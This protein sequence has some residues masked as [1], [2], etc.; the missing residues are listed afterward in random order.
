MLEMSRK[1][2]RLFKFLNVKLLHD[3]SPEN[4]VKLFNTLLKEDYVIQV[5]NRMLELLDFGPSNCAGVYV[6]KIAS[7][8]HSNNVKWF[9]DK[10]KQETAGPYI[11]EDLHPNLKEDYFF[12]VPDRHRIAMFSSSEVSIT[13]LQQY[14]DNACYRLMGKDK[15]STSIEVDP[16]Y[17]KDIKEAKEVTRIV[18]TWSYT[19]KDYGEGLAKVLDDSAKMGNAARITTIMTSAPGESLAV[20]DD[21]LPGAILNLAQSNATSEA[22][23]TVRNPEFNNKGKEIKANRKNISTSNYPLKAFIA[24]S[25]GLMAAA[26][27]DYVM[28]KFRQG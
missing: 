26:V 18:V 24:F 17:I 3:Q 6:G 27:Y 2:K 12:L 5:S 4:Y 7:Y 21:S 13:Y 23:A 20:D 19:N 11:S 14:I 28:S 25:S 8:M 10:T 22:E 16:S 1:E 9:S 15:V